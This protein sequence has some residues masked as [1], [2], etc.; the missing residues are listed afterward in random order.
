MKYY[1]KIKKISIGLLILIGLYYVFLHFWAWSKCTCSTRY[2]LSKS[3]D[4]AKSKH[5]IIAV[6]KPDTKSDIESIIIE[7]VLITEPWKYC[8]YTP[9]YFSNDFYINSD[10]IT[11]SVKL[12]LTGNDTL[13]S[14][15]P[16]F[17]YDFAKV[18][19]NF[20]V[21]FNNDE[22]VK[23]HLY[24]KFQENINVVAKVLFRDK[25]DSGPLYND[26]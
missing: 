4:D 26:D 22:T 25:W 10:L 12:I 13:Y 15:A 2:Y 6:Y 3:V 23:Y 19:E 17:H 8:F 18:P 14:G 24:L 11:D 20:I 16:I 21:Y 5:S 1:L 7:R 9:K